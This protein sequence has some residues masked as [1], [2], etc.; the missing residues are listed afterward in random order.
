M[1]ILVADDHDMVREM[2][3]SYLERE[4]GVEVRLAATLDEVL[5]LVDAEGAFDVVLLDYGMPGMDGLH[6]LRRALAATG[7]RPV[8]LMSGVATR[9]VAEEAL[10]AGASGFVPKTLGARS[11]LNALRFMAAGEIFAPVKWMTE[12]AEEAESPLVRALTARELQV[13]ERLCDGRS[14]KEIARDLEL[15]EVT[16]KLHVKTLCRKL[17]ARNRTHAAMIAKEAHLF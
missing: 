13:L 12:S 6:G 1:K 16:V 5:A 4:D 8:A 10:A 9:A 3:A 2:I 17:E 7:G 14:N 15:Q 11:M